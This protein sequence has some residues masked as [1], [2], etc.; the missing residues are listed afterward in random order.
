MMRI[1]SLSIHADHLSRWCAVALGFSIP[2]SVAADNVLLVLIAGTW[3][4]SG[5]Y[6]DKLRLIRDHPLSRAALLLGYFI[7]GAVFTFY[8]RLHYY[9]SRP[10]VA[11]AATAPP[12]ASG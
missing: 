12:G 6:R 3:L 10:V 2:I 11:V 4:A 7:F 1:Q 8:P 5:R 9:I